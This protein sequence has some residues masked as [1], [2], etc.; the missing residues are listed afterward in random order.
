V[1][2]RKNPRIPDAEGHD[3]GEALQTN[4]IEPNIEK[5]SLS[6]AWKAKFLQIIAVFQ[7]LLNGFPLRSMGAS[8][9]DRFPADRSTICLDGQI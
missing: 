7:T 9:V 8:G 6:S 5:F 2:S 3:L 1:P 4:T